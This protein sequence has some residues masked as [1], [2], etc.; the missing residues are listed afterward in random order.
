MTQ[1]KLKFCNRHYFNSHYKTRELHSNNI[2]R[3]KRL[4]FHISF[5]KT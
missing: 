1:K 5:C 3:N 4:F 2:F